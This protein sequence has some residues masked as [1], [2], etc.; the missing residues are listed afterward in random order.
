M[1]LDIFIHSKENNSE[2][3]E[4]LENNKAHFANQA[5]VV[6]N[7]LLNLGEL[8]C[9]EANEIYNIKHL[10]RRIANLRANGNPHNVQSRWLG[11]GRNRVKSY[12]I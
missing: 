4:N 6:L 1:Q 12:Y 10:P 2:S 3:Q 5:K 11:T 9:D 8:T 7:H